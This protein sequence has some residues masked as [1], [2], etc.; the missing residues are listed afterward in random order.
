VDPEARAQVGA[1]LD[2]GGG[3]ADFTPALVAMDNLAPDGE[4]PGQQPRGLF[5]LA[6][7]ERVADA[8]GGDR[9][10][11]VYYRADRA[12]TDAGRRPDLAQQGEVACA[13]LAEGKVLA[14]HHA[15]RADMLAEQA[16][17]EVLGRGLGERAV[18]ME[19]QH[20]VG[21]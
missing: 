15:R 4:R 18:E 19:H 5:A 7:L 17:D 2:V 10:A 3:I 13:P 16:G 8:A 20:G 9:P 6:G 12:V 14:R 21:P 11:A 1:E